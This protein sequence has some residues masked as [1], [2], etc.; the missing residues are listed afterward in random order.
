MLEGKVALVTGPTKGIG[1]AVAK[2]FAEQNGV[3]VLVCSRSEDRAKKIAAQLN[4]KT[5][6]AGIDVTNDA[7]VDRLMKKMLISI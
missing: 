3:I 7:S 2:E 5:D 6:F 1:L 4:G